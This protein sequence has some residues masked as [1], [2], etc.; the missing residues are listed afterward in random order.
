[1][2]PNSSTSH[3]FPR[4]F[5]ILFCHVACFRRLAPPIGAHFG[6]SFEL[7][8]HTSPD[9]TGFCMGDHCYRGMSHATELPEVPPNK[10]AAGCASSAPA[11]LW[12]AGFMVSDPFFFQ[13]LVT[14][15]LKV[16]SLDTRG[17]PWVKRTFPKE[18]NLEYYYHQLQNTNLLS[19]PS[20]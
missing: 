7:L 19:Q 15:W 13:R 16:G 20:S 1:M 5:A 18:K 8:R 2:N 14:R 11:L 9:D 6:Q 10:S 4:N 17:S 3:N 12:V